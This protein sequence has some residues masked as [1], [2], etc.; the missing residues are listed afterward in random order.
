MDI[1]Q[2]KN[3]VIL[4]NLPSN[5]IDEAIVVLKPNKKVKNMQYIK[6]KE[7]QGNGQ[8]HGNGYIV[9]E[10]EMLINN[11]VME[12]E[13]DRKAKRSEEWEKKYNRQKYISFALAFVALVEFI[14]IY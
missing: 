9:K 8:K 2:M 10:A 3:I 6:T 1:G 14:I 12:I 5:I 4:K 13:K 7:Q 11:Y